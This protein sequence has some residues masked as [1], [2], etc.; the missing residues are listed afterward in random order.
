[1]AL[2]GLVLLALFLAFANGS[3]DVSKGIATL[4]GSGVS[5]FRAAVLWGTL[6][7][8]AGGLVAAFASQGLVATFSG[9]G[10]LDHPV[11]GPAFL[12]AVATGA[13]LWV[14]FASRTGLPV[15]TTHAIAGAL[16]GAGI[17][18]EGVALLHWSSFGKAVAL[19]LALS[20]VVSIALIYA[21]FPLLRRAVSRV[22]TYCLC[23]E[24]DAVILEGGALAMSTVAAVP[25]VGRQE[26]CAG[27]PAVAARISVG[28]GMHWFSAAL[29][30]FARSL[31]DTPKIVALAL[32]A[33]A[34]LG[35]TGAGFYAAVALGMGAGSLV[36]GFRVTETLAKKVTPMSPAEGFAANAVT[37]V[38]VGLASWVALPVST[39]HVSAGAILGIGLR[40][41]A[42]SVHWRTVRD[43]LLAWL[44]TL[45]VAALAGAAAFAVFSRIFHV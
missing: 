45:P 8:V 26:V 37:A 17:V 32:A 18:E 11:E 36:A 42:K 24:R 14:L 38:L 15:S 23:I 25:I 21:V 31:N 22:E 41:E 44:V 1:M 6:W 33:A 29:T 27:S 20:P 43:M 4:V 30:S 40:R 12:A 5:N 28:D 10:F 7:T 16:A 19:P 3:N 2:A 34:T 39:T 35:V 9:K 13:A